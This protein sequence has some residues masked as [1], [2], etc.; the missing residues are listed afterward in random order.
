VGAV[1][2]GLR[3]A[4]GLP[5]LIRCVCVCVR[6][7]TSDY[8]HERTIETRIGPHAAL[9]FSYLGPKP[10]KSSTLLQQDKKEG[11]TALYSLL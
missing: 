8:V 4:P 2:V 5:Q 10:E 7:S 9:Q 11:R 3:Q 6:H 1:A